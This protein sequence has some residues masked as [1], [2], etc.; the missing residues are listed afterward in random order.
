MANELPALSFACAVGALLFWWSPVRTLCFFVPPAALVAAAFLWTNYLAVGQ[1][2]PAYSEFGG[3]P[4]YQRQVLADLDEKETGSPWYQYEG[5]HWR[6]PVVGQAPRH[7]IDWARYY[8]TRWRYAV[9]LLVGHHGFFSLSPIWLLG[10]AGIIVAVRGKRAGHQ[11][12]GQPDTQPTSPLPWFIAPL[13]LAVSA[14]VI[15]FYLVMSENYG[16]FA[17]GPR[18][19]IWLTP[20]LLLCMLPVADGW[21]GAAGGGGWPWFCWACQPSP[22]F[23]PTGTPGGIRGSMTCWNGSAG[24]PID[25][26]PASPSRYGQVFEPEA[27]ARD[28]RQSTP[29]L[30]L[31]AHQKHIRW[32][33]AGTSRSSPSPRLPA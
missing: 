9:H 12:S 17:V 24:S 31:R 20:M 22:L 26:V 28:C 30:A 21:L 2:R 3:P 10:F 15:G 11:A 13:T 14:V 25:G 19:L 6:K 5:S 32:N 33:T 29:S 18:W 1:L 4:P 23:I 27:Q 8:E 16:G 7:G